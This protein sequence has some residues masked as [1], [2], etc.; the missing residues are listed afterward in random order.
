ML[1]WSALA[2]F[3]ASKLR[4]LVLRSVWRDGQRAG[5]EE[6]FRWRKG[7]ASASRRRSGSGLRRT[8]I[9]RMVL[10]Q[11]RPSEWH[12]NPVNAVSKDVNLLKPLVSQSERQP[13]YSGI[14]APQ[15]VQDFKTA[16]TISAA[17]FRCRPRVLAYPRVDSDR[18]KNS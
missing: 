10:R 17:C 9:F 2:R 1:A 16:V 11:I 15:S 7:K 12:L 14:N 5:S 4:T 6:L 3:S 13:P 8:S 18:G